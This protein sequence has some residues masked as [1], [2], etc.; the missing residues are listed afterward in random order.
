LENTLHSFMYNAWKAFL[1]VLVSIRDFIYDHILLLFV[2]LILILIAIALFVAAYK[3]QKRL[4][5]QDGE[6]G[7][8]SVT[9][10]FSLFQHALN[11]KKKQE[12]VEIDLIG[13]VT[14]VNQ[15]PDLEQQAQSGPTMKLEKRDF[16]HHR[17]RSLTR[18]QLGDKGSPGNE[19]MHSPTASL[20]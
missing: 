1:I 20:P 16:R 6:D 13:N 11:R 5:A 14:V 19:S 2:I 4:A 7:S 18:V 3:L 8:S 15:S 12:R 10:G 17:S 9:G